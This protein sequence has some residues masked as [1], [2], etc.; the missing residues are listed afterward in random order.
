M[1]Y[2]Y[3]FMSTTTILGPIT[4]ETSIAEIAEGVDPLLARFADHLSEN[5]PT[6][7]AGNWE[8]LSH[9]VTRLDDRHLL[10]TA[11]LRRPKQ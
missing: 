3:A 4:I 7:G 9:S 2:D 5:L 8:A 6:Y 10:T 1:D 11:L